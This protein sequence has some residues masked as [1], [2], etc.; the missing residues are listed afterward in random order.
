MKQSKKMTNIIYL[1]KLFLIRMRN[2]GQK[3]SYNYKLD[4]HKNWIQRIEYKNEFPQ[5]I[6]DR[7]IEY[8]K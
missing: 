5:Y 2:P 4:N 7:E 8:F 6:V 3:L 1:K